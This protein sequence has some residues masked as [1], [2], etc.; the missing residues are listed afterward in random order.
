M[1]KSI[2]TTVFLLF[3]I[4]YNLH[5]QTFVEITGT[6]NLFNN[7]DIGNASNPGFAKIHYFPFEQ[8]LSGKATGEFSGV[9]DIGGNQYAEIAPHAFT[10]YDVGDS[11]KVCFHD[12]DNDGDLDMISGVADGTF[13]TYIQ[14][15]A[16]SFA[17]ATTNPFAGLDAGDNSSPSFVDIDGDGDQDLVVGTKLGPL[18]VYTYDNNTYTA[19]TTHP[20]TNLT[21]GT[22]TH[23]IFLDIDNDGD[24][25]LVCGNLAGTFETFLNN[26]SNVFSAAANNPFD[27]FDVGDLSTPTF[28]DLDKDGDMDMLS[29]NADGTFNY[30]ENISAPLALNDIELNARIVNQ[31]DVALDFVYH[32][33]EEVTQYEVQ[34]SKQS[35]EWT[36]LERVYPTMNNEQTYT[37]SNAPG[38][39]NFYRIKFFDNASFS[40]SELAY[41][42]INMKE[43]NIEVFPNPTK[44]QFTI[45]G[46]HG[47]SEIS[48]YDQLGRLIHKMEPTSAYE[49][50]IDLSQVETGS[51]FIHINNNG[52]T[53]THN[54]QKI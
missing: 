2:I 21:L 54:I 8:F 29:G 48:I 39:D 9:I 50:S 14:D 18:Q 45:N 3:L 19:Q 25:D 1:N 37:H 47:L 6:A 7:I 4:H 22:Y 34:H 15:T 41:V 5:S 35:A 38:G 36:T 20:F 11:S 40:Y 24:Q 23:P 53:S 51:Y 17:P 33:I 26:G 16:N 30:F 13:I 52:Q 27:T 49:V 31:N 28:V 43:S 12:L 42:N 46:L 32:K 44:E 10:G